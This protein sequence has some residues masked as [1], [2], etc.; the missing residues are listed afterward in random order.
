M[1]RN[2]I[3]IAL[4]CFCGLLSCPAVVFGTTYVFG[5]D[6]ANQDLTSSGAGY[7]WTSADVFI[8]AG[9]CY[10]PVNKTLSIYQGVTV[11]FDYNYGGDFGSPKYP[12]IEVRGKLRCY[13]QGTQKVTF[14]SESGVKG[15]YVGLKLNGAGTYQGELTA[16]NTIFEY[17]GYST[18]LID[19]DEGGD[20]DL[21]GCTIRYSD[22]SGIFIADDRG[23]VII[24][25]CDFSNIDTYGIKRPDSMTSDSGNNPVR[26]WNS[27]F[28]SCGNACIHF[29]GNFDCIDNEVLGYGYF[30]GAG[31]GIIR[32]CVFRLGNVNTGISFNSGAY[33]PEGESVEITNTVIR[34][35]GQSGIYFGDGDGPG[36]G[37]VSLNVNIHNCVIWDIYYGAGLR[38]LDYDGEDDW[39][40]GIAFNS[41][42]IGNCYYGVYIMGDGTPDVP[43]YNAFKNNDD[44]FY[45][46]DDDDGNC[47]I[48]GIGGDKVS[49]VNPEYGDFHLLLDDTN[50]LINVNPA[51]Q[52]PDGS[53]I[54]VGL[55][56][57]GYADDFEDSNYKFY[58]DLGAGNIDSEE[59]H[60]PV[61]TYGLTE[62]FT[63]MAGKTYVLHDKT[64]IAALGAYEFSVAGEL[65]AQANSIADSIVFK[66]YTSAI[67]WKGIVFETTSEANALMY[68][69]IHDAEYSSSSHGIQFEPRA[70]PPVGV[71]I[72]EDVIIYDCDGWGIFISGADTEVDIDNPHIYHCEYGGIYIAGAEL[73]EVTGG[74]N[75]EWGIWGI[76]DNAGYS[77]AAGLK[78]YGTT[79]YIGGAAEDE[80][81]EIFNN[82]K[83]GL[84]L[85]DDTDADLDNGGGGVDLYSNED[86][87][88]RLDND[89]EGTEFH[90]NNVRVEDVES[91]HPI[92][93][94]NTTGTWNVTNC[95]WG[96]AVEA[97]VDAMF[98]TT[99]N[100][101]Y[102]PYAEAWIDHVSD[103]S[104]ALEYMRNGE[105]AEAI[106]FFK[107]AIYN[108]P[109]QAH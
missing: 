93:D 10:V 44:T 42:I 72:L 15:D 64:V 38:I 79:C 1:N 27:Y 51:S 91:D 28:V 71:S 40:S 11:T 92:D 103:Y 24:D 7:F 104:I 21:D 105:Y 90:G 63:V 23:E 48:D 34:Q 8:I 46:C 102:D 84:W 107:S 65:I 66:G 36:G 32:N 49:L 12:T 95:W 100:I 98:S 47:Y 3:L 37:G 45:R 61:T 82:G 55:F 78:L 85:D 16:D 87:E 53:N 58:V 13:G 17:G 39:P 89:A 33:Q 67:N 60:F 56:G 83:Y 88:I 9:N 77:S 106:P 68:V 22:E 62:N 4:V 50:T 101:T 70:T 69:V 76:H 96:S 86:Y 30:D 57:G 97:T 41:N 43:A 18:A 80:E 52:D 19:V 59:L 54:D 26:I 99:T 35:F 74:N 108:D 31:W 29:A 6:G 5:E 20:L 73:V 2:S 25:N 109:E 14:T 75:P 81:L 94:H